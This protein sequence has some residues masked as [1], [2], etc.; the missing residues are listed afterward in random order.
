[1]KHVLLYGLI[2]FLSTR[3]LMAQDFGTV[4]T[5]TGMIRED[6]N[7]KDLDSAAS[8]RSIQDQAISIYPNPAT[9]YIWVTIPS[10][11]PT[12]Y[13]ASIYDIN[14]VVL[15]K[16]YWLTESGTNKFY[17]SLPPGTQLFPLYVRISGPWN[18]GVRIFRIVKQI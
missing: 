2:I 8:R 15:L 18:G 14:G 17:L 12:F 16:K 9:D 10:D 13:S 5:G 4:A 1:M 11:Y 6:R 3:Q 7:K